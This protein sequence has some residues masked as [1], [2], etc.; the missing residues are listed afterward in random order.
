MARVT[1]EAPGSTRTRSLSAA[2]FRPVYRSGRRSRQ[3]G[4]LVITAP[5][6]RG[7]AQVGIVAGRDVGNA[8]RRNRAKRRLREAIRRVPLRPATSYIAV[9]TPGIDAIAFD[10][11][12]E[13]VAAGVADSEEVDR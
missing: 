1:R 5:G 10:R 6:D 2:G 8:V 4:V 9:A 7:P 12:V 3:R 11:L 13:A